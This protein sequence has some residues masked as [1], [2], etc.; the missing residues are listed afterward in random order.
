MRWY[1]RVTLVNFVALGLF[2]SALLWV[3]VDN[4]AHIGDWTGFRH[5]LVIVA[6]AL[7]YGITNVIWLYCSVR[8]HPLM[9]GSVVEIR[10]VPESVATAWIEGNPT[11]VTDRK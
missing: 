2:V 5:T 7:V 11:L 6:A 8:Q 1:F 4:V 9:V 10:D 3:V